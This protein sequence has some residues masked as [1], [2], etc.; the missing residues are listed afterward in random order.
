MN[1]SAPG[2]RLAGNHFFHICLEPLFS[3]LSMSQNH[4]EGMDCW[5]WPGSASDLVGSG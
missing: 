3:N 1:I 5:V 4:L 2:Q